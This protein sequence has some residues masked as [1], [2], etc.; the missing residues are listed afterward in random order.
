MILFY[1]YPYD[2]PCAR[3]FLND[4]EQVEAMTCV[5]FMYLLLEDLA[6]LFALP[7]AAQEGDLHCTLR[8]GHENEHSG[9][10]N[11]IGCQIWWNS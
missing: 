8:A 3:F 6:A 10:E 9:R 1:S 11:G 5:G 2:E 4:E 7:C